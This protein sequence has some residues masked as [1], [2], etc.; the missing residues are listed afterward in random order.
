MV[1]SIQIGI[2]YSMEIC[3]ICPTKLPNYHTEEDQPIAVLTP[4]V[5]DHQTPV[6][7]CG[8]IQRMVQLPNSPAVGLYPTFQ[9]RDASISGPAAH[10]PKSQ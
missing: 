7:K 8:P 1:Q 10:L 4:G 2:L 3:T 9:M 5:G 6:L